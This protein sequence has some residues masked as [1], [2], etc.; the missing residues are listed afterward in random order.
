MYLCPRAE[1]TGYRPGKSIADV[2]FSVVVSTMERLIRCIFFVLTSFSVLTMGSRAGTGF[3]DWIPCFIL[4][5]CPS[6]VYGDDWSN[7]VMLGSLTALR[8]LYHI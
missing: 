2:C 3:V 4:L 8:V 5:R 7:A 6:T 1:V